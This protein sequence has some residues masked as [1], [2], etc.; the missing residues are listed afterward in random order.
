MNKR[1][2]LHLLAE[3]YKQVGKQVIA[4]EQAPLL[5]PVKGRY[6][7]FVDGNELYQLKPYKQIEPEGMI[8]AMA[9]NWTKE[10]V[11]QGEDV[12]EILGIEV[13]DTSGWY[14][15]NNA[16]SDHT[17]VA[18]IGKDN[19]I[20]NLNSEDAP[21]NPSDTSDSHYGNERSPREQEA[22]DKWNAR[23]QTIAFKKKL[24][25]DER[26]REEEELFGNNS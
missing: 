18:Y 4:E 12:K 3:A 10:T 5:Q 19:K 9:N 14:I 15:V 25:D 11:M 22:L 24:A 2:S 16:P 23:P 6:I 13:K 20:R 7:Y 17:F 8:M 1:G 26:R 21:V